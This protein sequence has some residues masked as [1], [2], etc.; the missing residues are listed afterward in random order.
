MNE[1]VAKTHSRAIG[2]I[3]CAT[4]FSRG[5]ERAAD[6]AAVASRALGAALVLVHAM[7]LGE[8]AETGVPSA[9]APAD[10]RLHQALEARIADARR[11]LSRE[12]RRLGNCETALAHGRPWQGLAA[13]ADTL[14]ATMI[15]VGAHGGGGAAERARAAALAR[16][17]GSS[18][19]RLVRTAH[20][21]ILVVP[22][23]GVLPALERS[24][25]LIAVAADVSLGRVLEVGL[26]LAARAGSNA[27]VLHV[28]DGDPRADRHDGGVEGDRAL[29]SLVG[30]LAR[31]AAAAAE[32][33]PSP[34]ASVIHA[35]DPAQAIL[36]SASERAAIIVVG[37][38][39]RRGIA[40]A[41]LGSVCERIVRASPVPV[42]VVPPSPPPA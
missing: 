35:R 17:L 11:A 32:V 6:F 21:P 8:G 37:T 42:L 13:Q 41:I 7:D 24:E 25:W 33:A 40:R 9:I 22:A 14:E 16:L 29:E 38:H 28:A 39:A 4:D 19:D 26:R 3:V 10:R 5:S 27:H 18:A 30:G 20:R 1:H 34:E 31:D 36:A 12:A 2:P 15:V 23:E